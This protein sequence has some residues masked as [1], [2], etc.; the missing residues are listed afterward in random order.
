ME[1]DLYADE[2]DNDDCDFVDSDASDEQIETVSYHIRV[3]GE[4][5]KLKQLA[6]LYVKQYK[7]VVYAFSYEEVDENHHM[8]GHL[9]YIKAPTKQ[10]ISQWMKGKGYSGK[11]YHQDVKTTS[12]QNLIYICK[13]L[14]IIFHNL[15]AERFTELK[16][17]TKAINDNKKMDQ[18]HKLLMEYNKYLVSINYDN[19]A[20]SWSLAKLA[21]W[22]MHHYIDVYDKEP[23]LAHLKGYAIYIA[24]KCLAHEYYHLEISHLFDNLF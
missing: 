4:R 17:M 10:S 15:T 13:D 14:D 18:R 20:Q 24:N 9:E 6:E 12:E 23:P 8:H 1:H 2:I 16:T 5:D 7:P 21:R 3:T 11:Y 22:I 19:V